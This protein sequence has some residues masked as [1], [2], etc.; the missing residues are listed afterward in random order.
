VVTWQ[1]IPTKNGY[2]WIP[3]QSDLRLLEQTRCL[4]AERRRSAPGASGR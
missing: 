3:S 4:M 2:L 1:T